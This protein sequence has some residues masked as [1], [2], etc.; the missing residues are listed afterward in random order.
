MSNSNVYKGL[1]CGA[2]ASAGRAKTFYSGS[3]WSPPGEVLQDPELRGRL[4]ESAV[5][6]HLINASTQGRLQTS[7]WRD[8]NREV[9][10][11]LKQ[12]KVI[13]ALEVKSG[14]T[15][16]HQPGLSAFAAA[17]RPQRSIVVGGDGI[18]LDEFLLTPAE[19]WVSG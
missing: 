2:K 15:R 8:K 18:E 13:T 10:F 11:V 6:A 4:V 1:R 3:R 17:H 7:Y 12:G 19:H 14:R 16:A 5:G 9:D